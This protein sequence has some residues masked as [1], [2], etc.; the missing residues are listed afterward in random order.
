MNAF[1]YKLCSAVA[2]SISVVFPISTAL[3]S[4]KPSCHVLLEIIHLYSNK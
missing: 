4:R 3:I 2:V 1:V